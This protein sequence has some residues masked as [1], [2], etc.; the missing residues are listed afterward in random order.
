VQNSLEYQASLQFMSSKIKGL[1]K[2]LGSQ[3]A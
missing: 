1:K 2:A 3:G